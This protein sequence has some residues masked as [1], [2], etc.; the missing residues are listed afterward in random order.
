MGFDMNRTRIRRSTRERVHDAA[1]RHPFTFAQIVRKAA[2]SWNCF[3]PV[4]AV[5]LIEDAP[6]CTRED[7]VVVRCD[8]IEP[9]K[10]DARLDMV[11]NWYLDWKDDGSTSRV[12]G[13]DPADCQ[14]NGDGTF[15]YIGGAMS[16][17]PQ[18]E[19]KQNA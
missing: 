16:P 17:E 6:A 4:N 7:S 5:K 11:L 19:K 8:G 9:L 14:D 2:R 12:A 15:T 1:R 10:F 18:Q 13:M 3:T